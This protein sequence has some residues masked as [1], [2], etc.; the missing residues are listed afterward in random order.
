MALDA[1]PGSAPRLL[2]IEQVAD[3]CQVSTKTV[4]RAIRS[5]ALTACQLG[6]GGAYRVKPEEMESWIEACSRRGAP[7]APPQSPAP[8]SSPTRPTTPARSARRSP[9]DG[10][11]TVA[12]GMGRA[13]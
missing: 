7:V 2:T 11:L 4:Y 13:S 3:L 5:G 10:R 8:V 6:R 1:L 9:G 12:A